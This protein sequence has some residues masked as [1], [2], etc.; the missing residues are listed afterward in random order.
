MSLACLPDVWPKLLF[1]QWYLDSAICG[2][3]CWDLINLHLCLRP[4]LLQALGG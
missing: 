2:K 4:K 1:V 3:I